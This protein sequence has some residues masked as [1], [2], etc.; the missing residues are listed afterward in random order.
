MSKPYQWSVSEPDPYKKITPKTVNPTN[1]TVTTSVPTTLA[2]L[3]NQTFFLGFQDQL[4]RWDELTKASKPQSF[5]PYNIVKI[6]DNEYE[7]EMAVAGY[8]KSEIEITVDHDKL[9]VASKK[10]EVEVG[11]V[12]HRGIAKRDWKQSF[13]LGEYMEVTEANLK[14]G[15]LCI[16]VE[17]NIPEEEKPKTIKI[18]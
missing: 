16:S 17:R 3:F 1:Y 7:I 5:P 13:V 18:K 12:I 6:T 2:S 11:D 8:S 4:S 15:L 10:T 9:T 14:D